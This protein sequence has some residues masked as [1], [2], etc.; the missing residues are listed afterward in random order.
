MLSTTQYGFRSKFFPE[1]AVLDIVSSCYDNINDGH[2]NDFIMLDL[3]KAF[4]AVAREILLQ[5]LDHYGI[6]GKAFNLFSLYFFNRQQYVATHGNN[7]SPLPIKYGVPQS[8]VLGPLLFL[9]YIN[10]ITNSIN[11]SP[12]LLVDDTCIIANAPSFAVLEQIL[13]L[14]MAGLS[15]WINPNKL[16][17]NNAK[18]Y[19]LIIS[20]IAKIASPIINISCNHS[21]IKIVNTVRYLGI[22]SDIKLQFKQH[23]A[24]LESQLSRFLG[25]LNKT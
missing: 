23:I 24:S 9:L 16:T 17:V 20:L 5:K 25:I 22:I 10:D 4:D 6:R 15:M 14:E 13:N 11:T 7:S 12:R 19:A 21:P 18:S 3:K 2:F 8:S 1:H